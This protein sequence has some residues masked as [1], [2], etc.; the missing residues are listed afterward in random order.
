MDYVTLAASGISW[1]LPLAREFEAEIADPI[2]KLNEP[3]FVANWGKFIEIGVGFIVVAADEGVPVGVISAFSVPDD[4]SGE[5]VVQET[6]YFVSAAHR[7]RNIGTA[8]LD[9]FEAEAIRRGAR[10][11]SMGRLHHVG[12]GVGTLLE[13]RGYRPFETLYY[14]VL[15]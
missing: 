15:A 5:T 2:I 4:R 10:R 13:R 3:A 8:L 6:W 14:K 7:G 9:A 11:I 12:E 1:I